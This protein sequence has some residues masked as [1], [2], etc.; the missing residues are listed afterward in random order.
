M[1]STMKQNNFTKLSL[2]GI[3]V[4]LGVVYGDIGTSPLYVMKSIVQGN[5]GL[6]NISENFI[7]GSLSLIFWT[8]TILTTIKYVLITLKADNK[9]E[10]GIFSLFTLVRNRAKWLIIPAMIGGSALLADGMLTPAVTVTSAI[11]GLKLIPSFNILFGMNQDIIITIVIIILS[12]LFFIQHFGTDLIGKMFGPI[13]LIW[14]SSLAIFGIIGLSHNLTL[15]RALS[16]YY[17]INILLSSD[18]KLGFFILG[19]VFL[20]TTGAEALYSDLGHVG[21][22]NIYCSWPFVKVCLLLN[23]FGQGAWVLSSKNN[24]LFLNIEDLNPFFQ[25]IPHTF[26]IFS[27][28]IS[29]LAAIIASQALI[30]GSFTLVSEAIKLN[31]FPRLHIKY[32]SH[33]KGQLYIPA[34]NTLLWIICIGIVLYFQNS[35]HMEAAYG[36]SITVTMLMTTILLFN[37]LLKQKTSFAAA[38]IMLIFFITFEFS[39]FIANIV[40]FMHGGFIAALIALAIFSVMYVWIKSYYIKMRLINN[41]PIEDYKETLNQLRKDPDR[42]KYTTNLVCLTSSS[43]PKQIERKIMY[44][45]LDKRPK[46]ADVYWFVNIHVTDE[47]YVAEYSVDTFGTSYIVKVQIKL[48]FRVPQKLNVFLRQISTELVE[49][50]E[51]EHQARNYTIIPDRKVGDFRFILIQEQLSYET[52]LNF[53]EELILKCK[54]FIKRYTVSP[55]RWFGLENSDVDVENVPLFIGHQNHTILKRTEK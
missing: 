30:S 46:K 37:Y 10:G 16:P 45:I 33:S 50:G 31:L 17:A 34:I 14:F 41:V 38:L 27:I 11:E 40:K 48:G 20:A 12:L 54:F 8:I 25:M 47:P 28:I 42:P 5:G 24:P 26:L 43:K 3:I 6:G 35:E 4:T 23:Y 36:L 52:E 51:I 53:W 2:A 18:N 13:M 44:S 15:L 49:S 19:S 22:Y 39:F 29:T 32:P 1:K 21:K 7:L 9:G 55:T